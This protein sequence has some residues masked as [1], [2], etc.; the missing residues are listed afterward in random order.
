MSLTINDTVPDFTAET[1]QGTIHFTIGS[2]TV[3]PFFHPKDSTPGLH[4]RAG[5][6]GR[7]AERVARR[8]AKVIRLGVDPISKYT[9]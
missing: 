9:Q 1:T 4:H 6:R 2:V 3:E 5:Q 7:P 8:N